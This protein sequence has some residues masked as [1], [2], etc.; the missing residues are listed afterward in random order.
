MNYLIL[1]EEQEDLEA[2]IKNKLTEQVNSLLFIIFA[3]KE[4][5]IVIKFTVYKKDN[6]NPCERT[7]NNLS[8]V[9]RLYEGKHR[10]SVCILDGEAYNLK[11][12]KYPYTTINAYVRVVNKNGKVDIEDDE[13]ITS[14]TGFMSKKAIESIIESLIRILNGKES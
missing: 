13:V 6:C 8:E 11:N 14:R 12:K 5:E 2:Q 10:F 1:K 3:M 9:F 4:R 7:I